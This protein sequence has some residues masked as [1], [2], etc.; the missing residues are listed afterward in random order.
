MEK[1]SAKDEVRFNV[2][3]S[4]DLH[5]RITQ[6]AK[7]NGRSMNSEIV[8]ILSVEMGEPEDDLHDRLRD[9][10]RHTEMALEQSQ[11]QTAHLASRLNALRRDLAEIE[12]A[13]KDDPPSS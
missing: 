12:R 5:A 8:A 13:R 9:E 6:R 2:R 11:T 10:M 1:S 3:I 7:A 4:P